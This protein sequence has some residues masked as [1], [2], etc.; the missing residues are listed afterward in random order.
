MAQGFHLRGRD[1][2]FGQVDGKPFII[3]WGWTTGG[4][5]F[6]VGRGIES[7]IIHYMDPGFG[8]GISQRLVAHLDPL[9][10]GHAPQVA[11]EVTRLKETGVVP[12]L[13][14]VRVGDNPASSIYVRNKRK[15]CE[16]AG[17]HSEEHD[18]PELTDMPALLGLVE[19]LDGDEGGDHEDRHRHDLPADGRGTDL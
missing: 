8:D 14:V 3:R 5:H 12:G 17:I 16:Q 11:R 1:I 15:A 6:L 9:L 19:R 13:A 4:G 18:L 7:N 2:L 10:V